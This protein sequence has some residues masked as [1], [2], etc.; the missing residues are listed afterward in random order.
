M[1]IEIPLGEVQSN[2]L[3]KVIEYLNYHEKNPAKPIERPLKSSNMKEN[4]SD[5]DADFVGAEMHQTMLF[6]V[7]L[8]LF[9]F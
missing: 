8:V 7:I 3:V 6:Q 2:V 9:S 5:W 1:N 4:V